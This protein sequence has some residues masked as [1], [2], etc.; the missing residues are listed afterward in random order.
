MSSTVTRHLPLLQLLSQSTAQRRRKLIELLTQR[1]VNCVAEVILNGIAGEPRSRLSPECVRHCRRNRR[2]V[3][4]LAY[5]R[6]PWTRRRDTLKK[7]AGRG[8]M[9]PL[10]STVIASLSGSE[11]E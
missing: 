6:Q 3:R 1:E 9:A 7:Q 11:N 10:L 8:W 4:S 5:E 2:A